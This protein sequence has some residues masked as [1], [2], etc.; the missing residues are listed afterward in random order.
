MDVE[1]KNP[2][3]TRTIIALSVAAAIAVSVAS[4]LAWSAAH[5]DEPVFE[6][7]QVFA[8]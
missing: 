2:R 6:L 3:R 4:N 5:P 7:S 1:T 8:D